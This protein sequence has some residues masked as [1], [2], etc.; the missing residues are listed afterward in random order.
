MQG[1]GVLSFPNGATF[2]PITL[3][4]RVDGNSVRSTLGM[5]SSKTQ[6]A[7]RQG[8]LNSAPKPPLFLG[9]W[10]RLKYKNRIGEGCQPDPLASWLHRAHSVSCPVS[11]TVSLLPCFFR[12]L[13]PLLITRP[14]GL[15]GL[16]LLT[17]P[18]SWWSIAFAWTESIPL[19]SP[20]PP[21]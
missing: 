7:W 16:G 17:P 18:L 6:E 15:R 2:F 13:W 14:A 3:A 1:F 9:F 10:R 11:V 20:P 4:V 21:G 8:R 5:V 12:P 19:P